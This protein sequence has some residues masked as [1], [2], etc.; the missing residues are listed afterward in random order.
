MQ[1]GFFLHLLNMSGPCGEVLVEARR[2]F[3]GGFN[4]FLQPLLLWQVG[5]NSNISYFILVSSL[6]GEMIQFDE[7]SFQLGWQTTTN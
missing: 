3:G 5:G 7:H 4:R 6:V 2:L 1:M